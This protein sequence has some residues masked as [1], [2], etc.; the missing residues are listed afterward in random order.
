M[1]RLE[2]EVVDAADQQRTHRESERM[3]SCTLFGLFYTCS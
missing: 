1:P 2:F 3:V